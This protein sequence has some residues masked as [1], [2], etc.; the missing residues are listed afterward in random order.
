MTT[1]HLYAEAAIRRDLARARALLISRVRMS[2]ERRRAVTDH[3]TWLASL[4]RPGT[5]RISPASAAM[6]EAAV[7]FGKDGLGHERELLIEAIDI[8]VDTTATWPTRWT[9]EDVPR[10]AC[11]NLPWVLDGIP[12]RGGPGLVLPSP[13][14]PEVARTRAALYRRKRAQLWGPVALTPSRILEAAA[15]G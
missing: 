5:D 9:A 12:L 2:T 7:A 8:L 13:P 4:V 15:A 1:L 3:L 10:V 14:D 6:R 11:G